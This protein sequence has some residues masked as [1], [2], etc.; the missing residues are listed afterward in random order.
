MLPWWGWLLLW[1]VLLVGGAVLVGLRVR[2]TWRSVKALGA[3][4]GRATEVLTALETQADRLR[5]ATEAVDAAPAVTQDPRL[6]RAEYRRRRAEQAARR[7][8]VRAER[9]PPWARHVH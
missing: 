4:V 2:S 1:L 6:L 3:E 9:L 8:A 5:E 7:Q